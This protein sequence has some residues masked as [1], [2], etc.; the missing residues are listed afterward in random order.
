MKN[1]A[2]MMLSILFAFL[3]IGASAG[4]IDLQFDPGESQILA[5]ALSAIG[6]IVLR[7]VMKKIKVSKKTIVG[8][9]IW[10]IAE[11]LLGDGVLLQNN[12]DKKEMARILETKSPVLK[13][14]VKALRK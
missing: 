12:P 3:L 6:M 11:G 1:L 13:E 5:G 2:L 4:A 8:K 9:I 10:G 14:A 7:I